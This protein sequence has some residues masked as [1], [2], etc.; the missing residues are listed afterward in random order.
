ME[1]LR[2]YAEFNGYYWSCGTHPEWKFDARVWKYKY[3][4]ER[5]RDVRKI[6]TRIGFGDTLDEAVEM[7]ISKP[8]II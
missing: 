8:K 5:G 1:K 3:V 6:P 7:C 2:E 4:R